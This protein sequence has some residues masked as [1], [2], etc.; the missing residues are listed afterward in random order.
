MALGKALDQRIPVLGERYSRTHRSSPASSSSAAVDVAHRWPGN[1]ITNQNIIRVTSKVRRRNAA[2][3]HH[4]IALGMPEEDM[5]TI[6][7]ISR[8]LVEN[9][10]RSGGRMWCFPYRSRLCI[11]T[12]TTAAAVGVIAYQRLSKEA[13]GVPFREYG[14]ISNLFGIASKWRIIALG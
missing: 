5:V 7:F 13:S 10:L 1:L 6:A 4:R 9:E 3:R 8:V 2:H 12:S 11:T 14:I